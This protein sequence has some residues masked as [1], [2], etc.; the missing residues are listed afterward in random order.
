MPIRWA[1]STRSACS[2]PHLSKM[3]IPVDQMYWHLSLGL[4][5]SSRWEVNVK[6]SF[7]RVGSEVLIF[8]FEFRELSHLKCDLSQAEKKIIVVTSWATDKMTNIFIR[9]DNF[10]RFVWN[11]CHFVHFLKAEFAVVGTFYSRTDFLPWEF[12][13]SY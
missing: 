6:A 8:W 4:G 3:G 11:R 10:D 9:N 13:L 7:Q 1:I 5:L 12:Q 2:M